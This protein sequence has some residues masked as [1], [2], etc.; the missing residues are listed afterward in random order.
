IDTDVH[1]RGSEGG[2]HLVPYLAPQWQKYF[3]QFGWSP[4]NYNP[5]GIPSVADL[6]RAD[7]VDEETGLGGTDLGQMQKD[8]FDDAGV[9]MAVLT[10]A[11]NASSLSPSWSEFKTAMTSAYNDWEIDAWLDRDPRLFGSIHVNAHD[12][13]GA[14][15]EI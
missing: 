2:H 3:T 10:G 9:D 1:E 4:E 13:E 12:V 5:F 15:A 7:A 14:V 8:L 11:M 6:Y